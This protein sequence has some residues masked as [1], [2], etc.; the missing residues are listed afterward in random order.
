MPIYIYIFIETERDR[1]IERYRDKGDRE[2]ERDRERCVL[3]CTHT[4]LTHSRALLRY[5]PS[6]K[7]QYAKR[8]TAAESLVACMLG[9]L[10][11]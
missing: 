6:Y 3:V 10:P 9:Q 1:E 8:S 5:G 2:I 7:M 11:S 4:E